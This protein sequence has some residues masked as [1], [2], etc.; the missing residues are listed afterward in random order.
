MTKKFGVSFPDE[1]A[2]RV[3]QPLSYGDS[4]S[5][6]IRRLSEVGLIVEGVLE[7]EGAALTVEGDNN[8]EL[9]MWLEYTLEEAL[10]ED[11]SN[12]ASPNE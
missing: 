12:T 9:R 5:E 2:E 10:Q 11:K 8:R 4:R 1:L 6:R 7:D 3:E